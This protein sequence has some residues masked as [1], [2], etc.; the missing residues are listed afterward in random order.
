MPTLYVVATPIGNLSDMTPRAIETLQNCGLIAAEDTRVTRKLLTHFDIKTP[1]I[2]CHRHNE[3]RR[4][5]EIIARMLDEGIDVALTSDAGTPAV[6]DPGFMLVHAAWEAGICVVPICGASAVT[7]ALS[8]GGFDAREFAFYGFLPREKGALDD[9]L[10]AIVKAGVPVAV[11]YESPHRVIALLERVVATLPGAL[12]AVCCDLS[13]FYELIERGEAGAVLERLKA[14]PNVAKGEYCVVMD[15][16]GVTTEE[17]KKGPAAESAE[18][19]LLSH[20]LEGMGLND[21]AQQAVQGGFPR[22]EVY[23]A[24]LKV[25]ALFPSP[26]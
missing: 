9:K 8:A 12:V 19:A 23:R 3:A 13:K 5:E 25:K 22:N 20:M 24:K 15:L 14:N 21:A 4:A 10:R 18:L 17:G 16:R 7:A 1:L 26:F 6:S 11:V 2:S